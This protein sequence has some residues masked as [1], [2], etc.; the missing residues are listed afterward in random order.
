ML[1]TEAQ[2][3]ALVPT[4]RRRGSSNAN[5]RG[6]T[7]DRRRRREWLVDTFRA[8]VDLDGQPAC[9]CYRCGR[10]LTVDT[11]TS[12]RVT[13]GCMG[14]RYL[15]DNLRPSCLDCQ[16]YTGGVLGAARRKAS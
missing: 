13:P 2:I 7:R 9:R 4:P 12:D 1:T 15:R 14:G 5:V 16:S 8:D 10:L 3:E 11:V 6:N